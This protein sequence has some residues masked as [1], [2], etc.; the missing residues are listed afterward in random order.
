MYGDFD[1]IRDI[2][3]FAANRTKSV[4][5]KY[6]RATFDSFGAI[7]SWYVFIED[8]FS[9]VTPLF[10]PAVTFIWDHHTPAL[11]AGEV[12]ALLLII[13][14][15][16]G[17]IQRVAN[18]IVKPV[19]RAKEAVSR[20]YSRFLVATG[21]A[22]A[23]V[24][25]FLIRLIGIA[26][27]GAAV[28][29]AVHYQITSDQLNTISTI[30]TYI[31]LAVAVHAITPPSPA[32]R[33]SSPTHAPPTRTTVTTISPLH[34]TLATTTTTTSSSSSPIPPTA[35]AIARA[36]TCLVPLALVALLDAVVS[37]ILAFPFASS[38]IPS[39]YPV[40]PTVRLVVVI[41]SF[42]FPAAIAAHV[43]RAARAAALAVGIDLSNHA[44]TAA[45]ATFAS[46]CAH[47]SAAAAP[48][49]PLTAPSRALAM[50]STYA[51]TAVATTSAALERTVGSGLLG[52]LVALVGGVCAG[53]W[54]FVGMLVSSVLPWPLPQAT[55]LTVARLYPASVALHTVLMHAAS[56]GAATGARTT[57]TP[58]ARGVG[59][60]LLVPI[61][62]PALIQPQST[63]AAGVVR[64]VRYYA[65]A[66]TIVATLEAMGAVAVTQWV[67]ILGTPVVIAGYMLLTL[68][69]LDQA[70][71]VF[72]RVAA[73]IARRD[74]RGALPSLASPRGGTAARATASGAV[75][76]AA[77]D[78]MDLP[79][80]PRGR[81]G[82]A[83]AV[84]DA[85]VACTGAD[86]GP[87]A[88]RTQ[89]RSPAAAR[90]A[91]RRTE[92][93]IRPDGDD[94]TVAAAARS[95]ATVE[96]AQVRSPRLPD[97]PIC[98]D[99]ADGGSP[100]LRRR[101]VARV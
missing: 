39:E 22:G 90:V 12:I 79:T 42:A 89:G 58:A 53:G 91:V 78:R 98:G 77:G 17:I 7:H 59:G 3:P 10:M 33:P 100:T 49:P 99:A 40:I 76:A 63:A 27:V 5:N 67:P 46:P 66:N 69:S 31:V 96:E 50:L 11:I 38:I 73:F 1:T 51:A 4:S 48:P 93:G 52:L 74:V 35:S 2:S 19:R 16:S 32:S 45:N 54:P 28:C 14:V 80:A 97:L 68:P 75:S 64:W 85:T 83:A 6:C 87:A 37:I 34:H 13:I 44:V 57:G 23:A 62:P 26:V 43:A 25:R 18:R 15:R 82:Q 56:C 29:G 55:L 70:G 61:T 81:G 24:A 20:A 30:I 92:A 71:H 65:V 95:V 72:I 8:L 94:E 41:V 47:A 9:D 101:G 88:G 86:G 36:R 21:R 84:D 60:A